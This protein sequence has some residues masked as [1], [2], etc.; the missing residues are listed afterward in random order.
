MEHSQTIATDEDRLA[1]WEAT[2]QER[3]WIARLSWPPSWLVNEE[4]KGEDAEPFHEAN[5]RVRA[6]YG[7]EGGVST[8]NVHGEEPMTADM[9]TVF[10]HSEAVST[11]VQVVEK[12]CDCGRPLA[13]QRT[14]CWACIKRGQR[15]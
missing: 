5:R 2:V 11:V 3:L 8:P 12:L 4:W 1:L 14:H 15:A 13:P 9:S 7:L 6:Q 10:I